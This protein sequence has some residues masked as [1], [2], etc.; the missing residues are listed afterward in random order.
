M[1]ATIR[2][3]T[4]AAREVRSDAIIVALIQGPDGPQLAAGAQD[5]DDALGGTLIETLTALG[6]TG[7][8]EEVTRT[9]SAG[10][11][12]APLI[13]A[14]G[15][16]PAA[17]GP[18]AETLRRCAGAAV[19][20]L[21]KGA[22]RTIALAMP[23][24]DARS[25][26]A[27]AFGALL[28]GYSFGRYRNRG[29]D[30]PGLELMLLA[31]GDHVAQAVAG[32]EVLATAVA[33]VRDMV[34]TSPSHLYPE[35]FAAE[36]G[37]VAAE[38]GLEIEMLDDAA[39]RA[40]GYGGITGVGQGSVH[41][42]RLVRL[43]YRHP[44]ATRT[45]VFAGKGITFDSGGLSLKQPKG[46]ETMKCDMSGAAAVLA[47]LQAIAALRIAVNAVGYLPL[48]ENMP[49]AGAQ[50]PSDVITIYGGTTVEVLNTDAEGRLVLADALARS[51]ED[52][53]DLLIDVATLTGAQ[54]VA[55]G[56]RIGAVM[57]NDDAVRDGV[58]DAARR[59]GEAMWP[60]PL[61]DE[62]RKGLDS[63]VADLAN[64]AG[65]RDGGMLVAGLF[66]REFVP[67][68]VRW[69][70]LDIAGPAFHEGEP[71]GYTAKG[72]TGF[73]VRTLVQV[74]QDVAGGGL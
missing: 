15:L 66:L 47:A 35:V 12:A 23:A 69:A 59:A 70:H 39:L 25:A 30:G 71:Y 26:E 22:V 9:V 67:D 73:A 62:L 16:G 46:M 24:G 14:V 36:A 48:A 3:T 43:V 44:E 52:S 51:G 17:A 33:L 13:A 8:P 11:L 50:R 64:V 45:V 6:A 28:G 19:R 65:E 37:K 1:T 41:P 60:M 56:N 42:P 55:L 10:R 61:P 63:K 54:V 74:A 49:G 53:P 20:S 7:G 34:N 18:D 2:T 38:A 40:E 57:S 31:D 72:G 32:A 5:V 4:S 21:S 29:K 27:V 58:T 68:G